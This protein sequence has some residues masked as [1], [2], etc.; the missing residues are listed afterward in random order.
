MNWLDN[1]ISFLSPEEGYRRQAYRNAINDERSGYDAGNY[2]KANSG[3]HVFNESA[4][5]EDSVN[6]ELVRARARDL[7][8]NSDVMCSLVGA[9]KRNVYGAGYRLK[10][11][12]GDAELNMQLQK[13]WKRWCKK[14]NCD[15]AGMQSFSQ[16]MRMAVARKKIDGG[17]LF[18]KC[19]TE[20][21]YLPFKLQ[22][23]EVDELDSTV[24][25]PKRAGN[26]VV[27]GVEYNSYGKPMGYF[28]RRYSL[29]GYSVGEAEYHE[30]KDVIFLFTKRR[31]S[32]IREMSDMAQTITRIRDVN[33]FISAVSLKERILACLSI[34][35]KRALPASGGRNVKIKQDIDLYNY[36]G[37]MLTPGM[38]Q[39][40][41]PGD[42]V[43]AVNPSGQATDATGFIKQQMRM[44]GSGQ[45]LSYE[46]TSRDMSEANYS[47][48]RQG[49]IEDELNY[50]ED[51]EEI[52]E[53]MDEVYESFVISM[54]LSGRLEIRNFWEDKEEYLDHAWIKAPKKWIDPIK[55]ANANRI[56]LQ[57][58]QKSFQ[59][60]AAEVGK[61]W[62]EMID[63]MAEAKK[64]AKEK[65]LE[66]EGIYGKSGK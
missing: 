8:K 58:G 44:V 50:T 57:T 40:L 36:Q 27:G 42:D 35:I 7:E 24:M 6:R 64:Y 17:I 28:F 21:G 46:A 4:E 14:R 61:D 5:S 15:V 62:K 9:Y 60:Q 10:A 37:K 41:N 16:M 18:L 45:G 47:S 38:M 49:A 31:P 12:T 23:I 52:M 55:E 3:W 56:A 63:E 20:D 30:A 32:Q 65:G 66:L 11:Q 19:Y 33:E 2:L 39:Y 48:A 29:D 26:R 1:I 25:S 13:A 51:I 59:D 53:V 34:F 22:A 43:F 54:V